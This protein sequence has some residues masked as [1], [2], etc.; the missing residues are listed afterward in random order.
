MFVIYDVQN[1]PNRKT[2]FIGFTKGL[3]FEL[4]GYAFH[5]LTIKPYITYD[6]VLMK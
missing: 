6:I 1:T 3:F 4:S 2:Q 5:K